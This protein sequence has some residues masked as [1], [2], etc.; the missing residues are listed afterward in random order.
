M[1]NNGEMQIF[2][3]LGMRPIFF[4]ETIVGPKQPNLTYM[5]S[6]DSL[7][8]RDE[9]WHAFG[10]DPEWKK[11]STQPELKDEQIVANISNVILRP[12]WFSV[13]R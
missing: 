1:F 8:A 5:L 9:L 4:G 11:L 3:R 7:A 2:E 6:Y 12:L 10:S 13:I